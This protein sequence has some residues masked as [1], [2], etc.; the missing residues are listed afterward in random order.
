MARPY[1]A[2]VLIALSQRSRSHPMRRTHA[3]RQYGREVGEGLQGGYLAI[4]RKLFRSGYSLLKPFIGH[5]GQF[6][7]APDDEFL[8]HK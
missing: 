4:F 3:H 1:T 2:F 8:D 7:P 6:L 5:G